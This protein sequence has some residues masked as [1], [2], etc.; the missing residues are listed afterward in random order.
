M[1]KGERERERERGNAGLSNLF[2]LPNCSNSTYIAY[3][4]GSTI[5]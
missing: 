1:N 4:P 5:V 2:N 3:A